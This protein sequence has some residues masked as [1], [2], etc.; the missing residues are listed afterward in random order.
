MCETLE[1]KKGYD[2][3]GIRAIGANIATKVASPFTRKSTSTNPFEHNS[4]SGRV[5]KGSALISAD[6]FQTKKVKEASKLKM[7]SASVV[8]AV[9]NFGHKIS[10]PIVNFARNVKAGINN[11]ILAIKSV[12]Q[13]V[14]EIGKNVSNKI[15]ENL[16]KLHVHKEHKEEA[17]DAVKILNMHQISTK[18]SVADLKS[19][20]LEENKIEAARK[21]SKEVA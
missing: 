5:F 4:F 12:P 20:W 15:S 21:V 7:M 2:P 17:K 1:K 11:T 10:Q 3:M 14:N 16:E 18:A 8:A 6:L 13:K 9:S 19:T